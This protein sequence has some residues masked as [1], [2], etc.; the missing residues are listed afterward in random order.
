VRRDKIVMI[1]ISRDDHAKPIFRLTM[2]MKPGYTAFDP[3]GSMNKEKTRQNYLETES[4]WK[5]KMSRAK[6]ARC[7]PEPERERMR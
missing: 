4:V 6:T 5:K 3:R 7:S 1:R 2:G